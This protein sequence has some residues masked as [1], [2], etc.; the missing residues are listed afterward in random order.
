MT[1]AE[2]AAVWPG[3]GVAARRLA[4]RAREPLAPC[5]T[6]RIGGAAEW[7]CDAPTAGDLR[8]AV[9]AASGVGVPV[10]VLGGGSN[11]LIGDG[12]VRGLVVRPRER[13]IEL[14]RPGIVRASA[15]VT[16]NGLVRWTISRGLAGLEG[17]AG[18][19]GTVG[20]AVYGNA[21]FATGCWARSW[22]R[23]GWRSRTAPNGWCRPPPWR[24]AMTPVGCRTPA[25]WRSG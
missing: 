4:I 19:P 16:L 13:R 20:G 25:R 14:V 18:T 24:S 8:S 11:V 1:I 6:F 21:H 23:W 5:T 10:T 7:F 15:G 17:W 9:A 12:G 3:S 2:P 22:P